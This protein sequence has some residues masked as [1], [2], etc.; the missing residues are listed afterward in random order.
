MRSVATNP[1][2]AEDGAQ[3]YICIGDIEAPATAAGTR[4]GKSVFRLCSE[5]N[6][7]AGK[8][9][10]IYR[11]IA[12][13][14]LRSRHDYPY[15]LGLN[16]YY[17]TGYFSKFSGE[18]TEEEKQELFQVW[19]NIRSGTHETTADYYIADEEERTSWLL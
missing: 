10:D 11:R 1:I 9:F 3:G 18:K 12:Y 8:Y 13:P 5:S 14:S 19:E 6:T 2:S 15:E 7:G 4:D 16:L 17:E